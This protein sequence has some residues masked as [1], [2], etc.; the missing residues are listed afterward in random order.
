L[1]PCDHNFSYATCLAASERSRWR[2]EDVIGGERRLD[3]TR[4][5][6][7]EPLARVQPLSFLTPV[8]KLALNQIRGHAYLQAFGLM[9]EIILPF[10]L[11]HARQRL[12]ADAHCVRALLA[13]ACEQAK[14]I[15]L[16]RRFRSD[17]EHGFGSPCAVVGPPEA[18]A[19]EVLGRDPLAVALF[20]VQF[21]WLAQAHYLESIKDDGRLDPQFR[22]L[23]RH[24][25]IEAAQHARIGILVADGLADARRDTAVRSAV[26]EYFDLVTLLDE[27]LERQVQLDLSSFELAS[28]R[29]LDAAQRA[30][31]VR[32][33]RAAN[34]WTFLGSGM[35]HPNVVAAFDRLGREARERLQDVALAFC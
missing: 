6:L 29:R 11:D 15:H 30:D 18:L 31:F 13:F 2:V 26:D 3:F 14:H 24:H 22:S 17:F 35:T 16:F 28:G 5:F 33:Q 12:C 21:E 34:R 32:I 19:G 7:P 1:P 23:L 4:P 10:V 27:T 25:W 20:I 9:G 8:E